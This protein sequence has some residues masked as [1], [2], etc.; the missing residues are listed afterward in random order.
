MDTAGE[1]GELNVSVQQVDRAVVLRPAGELDHDTADA[2]RSALDAALR[3]DV[4]QVVIDCA[5]LE[6]CDSTGLNLLLR[7]RLTAESG[8]R[9][10]V[11][12]APGPMVSRL[13]EITGAGE[14]FEVFP[15]ADEALAAGDPG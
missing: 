5:A 9:R 11:I 4:R 7:A 6:F 13:L 14:V 8:G 10:I 3:A 1:T 15:T 12:A 2:L